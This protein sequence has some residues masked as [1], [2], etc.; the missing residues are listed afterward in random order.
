LDLSGYS[1]ELGHALLVCATETKTSADIDQ[2]AAALR[3]C[4]AAG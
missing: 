1:P 3:A 4:L 2:Y